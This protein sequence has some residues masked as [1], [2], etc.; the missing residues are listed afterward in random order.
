VRL[1]GGHGEWFK[2]SRS[3]AALVGISSKRPVR[4]HFLIL[5]LEDSYYAEPGNFIFQDLEIKSFSYLT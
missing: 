2:L 5:G 1:L 3:I 4:N